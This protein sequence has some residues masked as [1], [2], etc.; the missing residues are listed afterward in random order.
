MRVTV[1]DKKSSKKIREQSLAALAPEAQEGLE[2]LLE[3]VKQTLAEGQEAAAVLELLASQPPG[4][5]AWDLALIAGLGR[6][7]HPAIPEALQ[8]HFGPETDRH[9]QKALKKAFHVLKTRQVPVPAPISLAAS[10]LVRPAPMAPSGCHISMVDGFGNRMI[11]L[12]VAKE[13][14]GFNVLQALVNDREGL[15]DFYTLSLSKK[16]RRE[17]LEEYNQDQ[18]GRMVSVPPAYGLKLIEEAYSNTADLDSEGLATYRRVRDRLLERIDLEA[19]P[20]L[21][22]LLPRLEEHE[23][24]LYLEKSRELGL[25]EA[26][27]TWLPA[28]EELASYFQK[29]REVYE[30]PLVLTEDQKN[31]RLDAVIAQAVAELFPLEQRPLLSR[32]LLE[33]AYFLDCLGKSEQARMAQAAGEDLKH[34]RVVLQG[35]N[36]FLRGL[37]WHSMLAIVEYLKDVEEAVEQE[38]AV[39]APPDPLITT[40]R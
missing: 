25:D 37:V 3:K 1:R 19:A 29:L 7:A 40:V 4:D 39:T 15:K 10:P 2:E 36:P 31:E 28:P 32:R 20:T 18:L 5:L 35:E 13:G 23:A 38:R 26:F 33:M 22:D 11:F 21:E 24:I 6:I 27:Q 17:L 9:R 14:L 16:R 30:S 8:R 12:Q 34:R